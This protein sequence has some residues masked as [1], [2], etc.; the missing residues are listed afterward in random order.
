MNDDMLQKLVE[1]V[2]L[3]FFHKPF[4]H[5]AIFNNRLRT[6]GGR[7]ILSSHNIEINRKYYEQFGQEELIQII[8]HELC[9]YH[10]HLE[11]KGYRHCDRDFRE[12]LKQVQAPRFCKPLSSP[13]QIKQ[14][15]YICSTCHFI[16]VRKRKV[17]TN[18][19]VCGRCR[20]KIKKLD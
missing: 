18:R 13:K 3:T 16:Y 1:Q 7:Y 8:K 6:T 4:K 5:K 9:H 2:S 10:L 19:Y 20:G 11:G 14:H 17:D 12:L 15:R